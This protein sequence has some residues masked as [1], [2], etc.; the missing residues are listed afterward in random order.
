[1]EIVNS[2]S[3]RQG[4]VTWRNLHIYAGIKKTHQAST[5][6]LKSVKLLGLNITI[7]QSV[8]SGGGFWGYL[9]ENVKLLQQCIRD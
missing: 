8:L 3:E 5:G 1:M 4:G 6:Y 2:M 7:V 9:R